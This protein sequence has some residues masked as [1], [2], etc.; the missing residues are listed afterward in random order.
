MYGRINL[1]KVNCIVDDKIFCV[2]GGLSIEIE[3]LDDV[4]TK[5]K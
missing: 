3:S 4:N 2:H 5:I 1:S